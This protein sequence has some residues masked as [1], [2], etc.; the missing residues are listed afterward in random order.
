LNRAGRISAK[1]KQKQKQSAPEEIIEVNSETDD[2]GPGPSTKNIRNEQSTIIST[3]SQTHAP[4]IPSLQPTSSFPVSFEFSKLP[5]QAQ[6]LSSAPSLVT[7]C[8][9]I[10]MYHIFY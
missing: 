3:P 1:K 2:A 4:P 9:V 10:K 8:K 7:V 5:I 6:V